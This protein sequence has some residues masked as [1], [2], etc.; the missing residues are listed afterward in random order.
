MYPVKIITV[1]KSRYLENEAH[2]GGLSFAEMMENAQ[3]LDAHTPK[4]EVTA[5]M[6]HMTRALGVRCSTCHVGEE[7][8]PLWTYDFA[9]DEKAEKRRAREMLRL[10]IFFQSR[11]NLQ[12]VEHYYRALA[13]AVR[14]R[15]LHRWMHT[16][17]TY[18]DLHRKVAVYLSAE[19]LLGVPHVRK[20]PA[21]PPGLS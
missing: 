12:V 9:S 21:T 20:L 1:E 19:F 4:E 15:M 3:V 5:L 7:G 16:T 2:K 17:Q 11:N 8:A 6:K 14:D 13:L 18:F 10:E